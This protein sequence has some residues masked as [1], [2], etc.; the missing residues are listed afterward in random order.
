MVGRR[1]PWRTRACIAV[2]LVRAALAAGASSAGAAQPPRETQPAPPSGPVVS[3]DEVG[4]QS[5]AHLRQA[6]RFVDAGRWAEAVDSLRRVMD[7][8][9]ERWIAVPDAADA[10]L[11]RYM[12]V[13]QYG[14][15]L[16]ARWNAAGPDAL[17]AYRGAVDDAADRLWREAE[18]TRDIER[19]ETLAEKY[20]LASRGDDAAARLGEILFEQGKFAEARR[21]WERL[22]PA[23]RV[24]PRLAAATGIPAG[25][26]IG[27]TIPDPDAADAWTAW[28]D[29]DRRAE[30]SAAWL[31]YPDSN[32]SLAECRA[33]LALVSIAERDWA[34]AERER[35][36]LDRAHPGERGAIA[37]RDGPWSELVADILE[38]ERSAASGLPNPSEDWP[39]FAGEPA[40]SHRVPHGLDIG[41]PPLWKLALPRVDDGGDGVAGNRPRIAESSDGIL[42]YFPV[43]V[44]R[45]VFV[46]QPESLRAVDLWTGRPLFADMRS[47]DVPIEPT[48]AGVFHEH[49][50]V[51][52]SIA[53]GDGRRI[54][55]VRYTVTVGSDAIL[56]RMGSPVSRRHDGA[57]AEPRPPGV[58]VGADLAAEGRLRA[59][60]PIEPDGADWAFEGTPVCAEGRLYVGMR[61]HGE[62]RTEL[63]VAAFDLANG[64][65]VWRRAIGAAEPTA[66]PPWN[67]VFHPLLALERGTVY[68]N[69][70]LGM[71]AALSA[72]DG[73]LRWI[74]TYPRRALA[75]TAGEPPALHFQRSLTPPV[76]ANNRMFAAPMDS[77]RLFALDAVS[78]QLLW[79]SSAETATDIVHIL[80]VTDDDVI[81]SGD[82]LYWF[83]LRTGALRCRFPP[84]SGTTPG[85]SGFARPSPRGYG[86][87]LLAADGIYW[88]TRDALYRFAWQPRRIGDQWQAWPAAM[89]R[90]WSVYGIQ[91]GNL[92][93]AHHVLLVAGA[94]EL[95]AIRAW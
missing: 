64:R 30:P 53:V 80:G 77:D 8:D 33:R 42:P 91:P 65:R 40:R 58:I 2:V 55:T 5:L 27:P 69:S 89:P 15:S 38:S 32:L 68:V 10:P 43:I 34:G 90:V 92:V 18:S 39:T 25:R 82:C 17:R 35:T 73:T 75:G 45:R 72:R 57:A 20:F 41:G 49:T 95:A 66:G 94:T 62:V 93:A 3:V 11:T 78:G 28:L 19:L 88:P 70:N 56:A 14:H 44:G 79:A 60:F 83:D 50:D 1:G 4:P 52:P 67:E 24:S 31:A 47:S 23:L 21:W 22:H 7:S 76:V 74:A 29:A 84:T 13:V 61:R 6:R 85:R 54:G 12:T 63:L 46:A 59:G 87:G 81:A 36:V 26:P 16:L 37:G 51:T 86:R 71:L 9:G 48:A